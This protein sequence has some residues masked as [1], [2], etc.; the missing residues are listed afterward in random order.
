MATALNSTVLRLG[1]ELPLPQDRNGIIRR[2]AINLTE[3]ET[4]TTMTLYTDKTSLTLSGLHPNYL[5]VS[6]IAAETV[7][8][9]PWSVGVDVKLPE[10]GM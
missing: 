3:T 10:D 1:W 9:G 7:S 2:Y 5:Y 4:D 8:T 6:T